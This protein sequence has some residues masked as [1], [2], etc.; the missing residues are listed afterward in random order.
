MYTGLGL[1]TLLAV[2]SLSVMFAASPAAAHVHT[3]GAGRAVDWYP[4][5]CC[6]GRD[7]RPVVQI[8]R[9]RGILWMTTSDGITLAVDPKQARRTSQ[10][11]RWHVCYVLDDEMGFIVRCIFE[12]GQS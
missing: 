10:D 9:K 11:D 6:H 5:D 4:D 1:P 2:I 8:Q 7:C 3:D 12:P